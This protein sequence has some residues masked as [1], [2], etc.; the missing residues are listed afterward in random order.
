MGVYTRLEKILPLALLAG[1][2]GFTCAMG[3]ALMV[4]LPAL[5]LPIS[6]IVGGM[7]AWERRKTP[8]GKKPPALPKARVIEDT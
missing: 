3:N 6:L 1:Y 4:A 7:Y 5:S 8:K 2:V